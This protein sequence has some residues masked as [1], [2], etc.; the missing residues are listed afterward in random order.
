MVEKIRVEDSFTP[1]VSAKE[2]VG[3]PDSRL[4]SGMATILLDPA[5]WAGGKN[6]YSSTKGK[7]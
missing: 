3:T 7:K 1:F 4:L 5:A 6:T 2:K